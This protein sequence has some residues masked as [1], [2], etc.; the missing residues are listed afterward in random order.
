M[1][2]FKRFP[3]VQVRSANLSKLALKRLT[4]FDFWLSHDKNISLTCRHFGIS[5]DSFYLWKKR[6]NPYNLRSLEDNLKTR[7]PH[8]LRQMTTS[9]EVIDL[10]IKIRGEDV[11]KSK[12]EIQAELKDLHDT[13]LGYNTIQ[14]II[15][16]H[17]HLL[18]TQHKRN[19]KAHKNRSI[20]RLKAEAHLRDKD[21]GSLVQID[22]KHLY[23]LGKRFYLF[24]AV[25][26]KS[27]Y[28][29]VWAYKSAS[30]EIAAHF[31]LKVI[32]Y[33]PF[34]ITAVNTDNGP[35]YLL[36]FHK[37]CEKLNIPH[38]FNH[39][40]TPKMNGRAERLIQTVEYEYFNYQEDLI[41][42]LEEINLRCEIFNDKYNNK[43]YHRAIG[44]QT[45]ANYVKSYLDIKKGEQL[46]VH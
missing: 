13:R 18:N 35:E 24:V 39:P 26:C 1:R 5:R 43:R 34:K 12:Y 15:N 14:K 42:D 16:R 27:R 29:F 46:Y 37:M 25:D 41:D 3:L 22:T 40:H 8:N 6:F 30:S 21:L 32:G 31:L 20:A 2:S 33:F 28:G 10:V 7:T 36:N 45:P 17:I 19:S 38:Y 9:K 23:I 11:E 4:W 44:Y